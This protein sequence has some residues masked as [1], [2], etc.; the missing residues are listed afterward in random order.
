MFSRLPPHRVCVYQCMRRSFWRNGINAISVVMLVLAGCRPVKQVTT[1]GK[2][3]GH[4]FQRPI[5][6]SADQG[7]HLI[8]VIPPARVDSSAPADTTSPRAYARRVAEFAAKHYQHAELKTVTVRFISDDQGDSLPAPSFI[9]SA[10]A[11]LGKTRVSV[12]TPNL[13]SD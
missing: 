9:W 5:L 1:L 10:D 11:L 3:I 6:V 2:E 12:G 4:E 8:L 7:G 13:K